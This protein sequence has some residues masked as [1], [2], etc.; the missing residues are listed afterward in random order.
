MNLLLDVDDTLY[1]QLTPFEN[2][3]RRVFS[4]YDVP[5]DQLFIKSRY[6]S[7]E[8]FDLVRDSKMDKHE[9]HIYRISKAFAHLGYTITREEAQLFQSY[10]EEMQQKIEL[11]PEMEELLNEAKS[12]GLTLGIITNG[13]ADH[14]ANK[15]KQL[16]VKEWVEEDNIFISGE[17]GISKPNTELF[18]LVEKEMGIDRE[19]TYYV[20]DSFRNDVVGAKM[21]GW[22]A[23]WLNRRGH[24]IPTDTE[25]LPDYTINGQSSPLYLLRRIQA[26]DF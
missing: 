1:D 12:Q 15:I 22:N 2:A 24:D 25:Y 13:P 20:G 14:Q 11:A 6:Y 19:R 7:D 16:K 3:Y 23:V 9:M 26:K 21:A 8:V 10:Y 4:H 18:R 5:I 17:V